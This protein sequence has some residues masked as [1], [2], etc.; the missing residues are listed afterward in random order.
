[1]AEQAEVIERAVREEADALSG[2]YLTFRLGREEYGVEILKV[3]E[4]IG[5][6]PIT[7]VPRTPDFVRG[8][9]NLRGRVIPVVDLR[10]KFGMESAAD[11]EE[12][13]IIVLDAVEDGDVVHTGILVDS[14]SEVLDIRGEDTEKTPS[15]GSDVDSSFILGIAKAAGSVRILLNMDEILSSVGVLN[16]EQAAGEPDQQDES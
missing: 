13:C 8:V 9:I 10:K 6:M 4:I 12:T 1:M 11:T 5:V 3:R 14:V 7:P 16:F 15:F 2:K